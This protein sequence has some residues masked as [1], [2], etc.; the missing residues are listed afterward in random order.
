MP[1]IA[2]ACD[3]ARIVAHVTSVPRN[4][5]AERLGD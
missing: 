2:A 3:R 1:T 5:V 4:G